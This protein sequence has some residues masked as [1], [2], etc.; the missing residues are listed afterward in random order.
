[1]RGLKELLPL[2]IGV[3][4]AVV[5]LTSW[6]TKAAHFIAKSRPSSVSSGFVTPPVSSPAIVAVPSTTD[7]RLRQ[8]FLAIRMYC[9][10]YDDTLPP[11]T[12]ATRLQGVLLPYLKTNL[13]WYDPTTNSLFQFNKSLSYKKRDQIRNPATMVVFYQP[14]PDPVTKK[15]WVVFLDGSVKQV[16]EQQWQRLSRASGITRSSGGARKPRK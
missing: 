10:D 9:A 1:M 7:G 3:V 13:T 6:L 12:S 16:D 4:I 5:I 15:R 14:F 11:M 2:I 8:L